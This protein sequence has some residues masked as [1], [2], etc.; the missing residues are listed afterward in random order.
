MSQFRLFFTS[1]K[2]NIGIV[3]QLGYCED[4]NKKAE[5]LIIK[6]APAEVK[7]LFDC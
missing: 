3:K 1:S 2:R 7:I 6:K 4:F 5:A